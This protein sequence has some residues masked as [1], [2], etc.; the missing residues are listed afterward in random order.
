MKQFKARNNS[1]AKD[2]PLSH[3]VSACLSSY[4]IKRE[5]EKEGGGGAEQ[6][7]ATLGHVL[8]PSATPMPL[9]QIYYRLCFLELK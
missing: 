2:V 8:V 7:Q 3:I 9:T 1:K 5:E 6:I 4:T